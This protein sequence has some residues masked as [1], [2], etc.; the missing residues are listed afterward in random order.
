MALQKAIRYFRIVRSAVLCAALAACSSTYSDGT[1]ATDGGADAGA[2]GDAAGSADSGDASAPCLGSLDC[3][4]FVF[5]TSRTTAGDI[6]GLEGADTFCQ[7][8][9]DASPRLEGRKFRAWLSTADTPAN[10]RLP[11]G[12]RPY[13]RTDGVVVQTSFDKIL[14]GPL[15]QPIN[16][17]ENGIVVPTSMVWTGSSAQGNF[18]GADC[19]GWYLAAST[20]TADVGSASAV[21]VSWS[22]RGAEGACHQLARFYCFEN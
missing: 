17:D 14:E 4:R 7:E 11:R 13:R 15:L 8:H 19:G 9:A 18:A 20:Q 12:T 1:M 6:D 2:G 22:N 16:V 10:G 3:E 5:V 21:D